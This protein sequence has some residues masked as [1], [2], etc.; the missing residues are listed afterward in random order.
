LEIT[1]EAE[2][3]AYLQQ[4]HYPDLVKSE[5]P[6]DTFDCSSRMAQHYIE[7]KCRRTH[8]DTLLIEQMKYRHLI[9][10]SVRLQM[11]PFYINSTPEGI[12]S[13]DLS[14]IAEPEWH[15]HLMP[16]TTDFE[17]TEKK[18]KLVGYLDIKDGIQI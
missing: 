14:E 12:F 15:T 9:E 6:Y 11:W 1:T 10:Q 18:E 8:Y 7:L 5:S 16:A 17:N 4:E 13:F 3:F 2:L